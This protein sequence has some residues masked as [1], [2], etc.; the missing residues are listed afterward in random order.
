MVVGLGSTEPFV[1]AGC[2]ALVVSV[3]ELRGGRVLEIGCG[4]GDDAEGF[5]ALGFKY[6]GIDFSS[7]A[8]REG[9]ARLKDTK[10][11]L[12]A[13]DFES[14]ELKLV[15]LFLCF[16]HSLSPWKRSN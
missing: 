6:G 7:E 13:A 11:N 2:E 8:I 4:L 12:I 10:A 15:D 1:R 9:R 3:K 14:S 5:V 16:R